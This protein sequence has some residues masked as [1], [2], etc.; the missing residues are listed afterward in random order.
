[1]PP[2]QSGLKVSLESS[3]NGCAQP[4]TDFT[5]YCNRPAA[6]AYPHF[7]HVMAIL[8]VLNI[9]I[10]LIIG[11]LKPRDTDYSPMTTD[12]VNVEP[13][14]NAIIAGALITALVLSTYLIF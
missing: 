9:A 8:F 2:F 1:L 5:N 11:M 14:K 10:M 6:E 13:W 3:V 12:E 4:T 7:L